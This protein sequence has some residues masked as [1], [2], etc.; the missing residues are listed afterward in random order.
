M[1]LG[2]GSSGRG[3][4]GWSGAAWM[5]QGGE[6]DSGTND[7]GDAGDAGQLG[8]DPGHGKRII[9]VRTIGVFA[10]HWAP[11]QVKTRLARDIGLEPAAALARAML[12]VTLARVERADADRKVLLF[13]PRDREREFQT[14]ARQ[15]TLC[16]QSDGDLGQR[17]YTFFDDQFQAGASQVVV[18]GSDSPHLPPNAIQEV[19]QGLQHFDC[20]WGPAADGG[21]YAL[22]LRR[23][24]PEFFRQIPWSSSEVLS[25]SQAQAESLGFSQTQLTRLEDV[26]DWGSL[27]NCLHFCRNSDERELME[28]AEYADALS[29]T[30]PPLSS[31]H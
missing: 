5:V 26:D 17:M 25:R 3:A 11:G 13:S 19:W 2:P 16:P 6:A 12:E 9:N 18:L 15:W 10:K 4:E 23:L 27:Q 24:H 14:V 20:V 21:Y 7:A 30:A 22:G 28:F 29:P 8:I 1:P 31:D